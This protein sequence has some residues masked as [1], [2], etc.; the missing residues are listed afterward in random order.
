MATH[1]VI[2]RYSALKFG[3]DIF[4]TLCRTRVY[5]ASRGLETLPDIIKLYVHSTNL[6][7]KKEPMRLP[8]YR[9]M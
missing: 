5:K 7:K 9:Q 8:L 4:N 3:Q 6:K 1:I 2:K